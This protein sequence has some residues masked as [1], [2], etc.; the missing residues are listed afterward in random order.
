VEKIKSLGH[1]YIAMAYGDTLETNESSAEP[2]RVEYF[3]RLA[4]FSLAIVKATQE[5]TEQK[6]AE[7]IKVEI[8]VGMQ[9]GPIVAGVIGKKK[10]M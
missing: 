2:D 8:R 4:N 7:G 5:I 9:V 6:K 1:I 10:L 3:T